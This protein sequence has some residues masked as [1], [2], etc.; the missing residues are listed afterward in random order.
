MR[1]TEAIQSPAAE[2]TEARRR[3]VALM[4]D[5]GHLHRQ[6]FRKRMCDIPATP[7]EAR[8]LL[9]LV[10]RPGLTQVQLADLLD[11]QPITLTRQLDRLEKAGYVLRCAS[12]EDRRVRLLHLT[13]QGKALAKRVLKIVQELDEEITAELADGTLSQLATSLECM[14]DVLTRMR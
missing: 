5:N 7:G 9:Y 11:I 14:H 12:S 8:A 1:D 4:R 3:V 2:L 10:G 6:L 13:A